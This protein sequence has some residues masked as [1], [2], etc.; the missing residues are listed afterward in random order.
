SLLGQEMG[1]GYG[2]DHA[3]FEGSPDDY[4]DPWDVMSTAAYP[5]M[6]APHPEFTTVG[7][8]L[9]AANMRSRNWLDENRVWKA[10]L[11]TS[12]QII[13]LRPLPRPDLSGF[14]AAQL[15]PYLVEFRVPER[16][17]AAIP[18]ACVLVH[19]FEANHSYLEPAIS[20][21]QDIV[22]GDKFMIGD[23]T[24]PYHVY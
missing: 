2:L 1:H 20:G 6:E 13:Q 9:N 21:S 18:R 23:P 22:S 16:W 24:F 17:D 10:P 3:R 5:W 19:R 15:G 8:G 7:P 14:L 11:P 4:R 12:S